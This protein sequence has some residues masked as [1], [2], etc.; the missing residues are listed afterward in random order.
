MP[1]KS[2]KSIKKW[3]LEW[4]TKTR[5]VHVSQVRGNT[6]VNSASETSG[7]KVMSR[8]F[9]DFL[10][11]RLSVLRTSCRFQTGPTTTGLSFYEW[12]SYRKYKQ[13]GEMVSTR[14]LQSLFS[15]D[16]KFM[17]CSWWKGKK[18]FFVSTKKVGFY[19][20][21]IQSCKTW[22]IKLQ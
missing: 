5:A 9:W 16:V 1:R 14:T 12:N 20:T 3:T 15:L 8:N 22:S 11:K 6:I 2:K 21:K 17:L 10:S 7:T 18:A 19:S 13:Q 4:K